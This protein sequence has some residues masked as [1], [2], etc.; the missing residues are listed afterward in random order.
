MTPLLPLS[1]AALRTFKELG[2]YIL[3]LKALWALSSE[4]KTI[5]SSQ[6]TFLFPSAFVSNGR[7]G[8][9]FPEVRNISPRCRDMGPN[10]GKA[11]G[12]G[13][14]LVP[15]PRVFHLGIFS[16]GGCQAHQE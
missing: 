9:P 1:A 2:L 4:G 15:Y 14:E 13:C 10:L 12:S 7:D 5:L 11:W 16:L 3:C 6:G 8:T